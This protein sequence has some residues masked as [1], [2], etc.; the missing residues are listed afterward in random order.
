MDSTTLHADPTSLNMTLVETFRTMVQ[1]KHCEHASTA[2]NCRTPLM[3]RQPARAQLHQKFCSLRISVYINK[4][5]HE[6]RIAFSPQLLTALSCHQQ[7]RYRG[8]EEK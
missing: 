3:H 5:L 4:N 2:T 1:P 6:L 7:D 8:I